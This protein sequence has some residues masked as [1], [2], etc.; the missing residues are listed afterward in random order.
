MA[1]CLNCGKE[2]D[3]CLCEDCRG[4]IDIEALCQKIIEYR[5]GSGENPLWDQIAS[6]MA[7]MS[8]FRN[9]VFALAD[10]LPTPCR[11][12]VT[13]C[14]AMRGVGGIDSWMTDVEEAWHVHSDEDILYYLLLDVISL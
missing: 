2:T 7:Y 10:E 4:A 12:V 11:T 14:G 6:E 9:A 8:D 5:S 3:Y 13:I 1:V